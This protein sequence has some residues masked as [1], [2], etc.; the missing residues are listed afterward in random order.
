MLQ[1]EVIPQEERQILSREK[2]EDRPMS[3]I[4]FFKRIR[5]QKLDNYYKS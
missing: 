4:L 1:K 2:F 5:E 3:P